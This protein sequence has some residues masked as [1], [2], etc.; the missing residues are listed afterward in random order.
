MSS[1]EFRVAQAARIRCQRLAKS[2]AACRQ[3]GEYPRAERHLR[4]A[5]E[6]AVTA[7]GETS[8]EATSARNEIGILYKC[9]GRFDEAMRLYEAALVSTM[10]TGGEASLDAAS[11]YHNIAGLL[12]SQLDFVRAEEPA[13]RAWTISRRLLGENDPRT[14]ADASAYAAVLD[15]LGEP[16]RSAAIYRRALRVFQRVYGQMH[17]DVAA[18][19]HNL[20]AAL[21][22]RGKRREALRCY[23]RSLSIRTRLLGGGVP[24]VALTQNNIGRLLVE[25]GRAGDAVPLLSRAV[26]ILELR[27]V[28]GHPH[29]AAARENWRRAADALAGRRCVIP[30]TPE[31]PKLEFQPPG[32]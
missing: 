11:L 23:R 30:D 13:R 14:M 28:S 12:H 4:Q 20:G 24:E 10:S 22:A 6:V 31:G 18:T 26:A 7:L 27:L 3:H 25:M 19:L 21:A 1:L 16:R 17:E 2:G 8:A 9:W 29:L 5:L 32:R 15:G